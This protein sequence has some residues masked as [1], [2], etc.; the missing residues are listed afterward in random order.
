MNRFDLGETDTATAVSTPNSNTY[1]EVSLEKMRLR[2]ERNKNK[3][4]LEP[5]TLP[6]G[7]FYCK[8]CGAIGFVFSENGF[9]TKPILCLDCE[10][11]E[12]LA[13]FT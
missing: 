7:N 5:A 6:A 1:L 9:S 4:R 10:E 12:V 13:M 11:L 2:R 3:V 8:G